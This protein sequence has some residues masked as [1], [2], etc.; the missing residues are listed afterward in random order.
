MPLVSIV[1]PTH[2]RASMVVRAVYSA[3]RQ[4]VR[5]VEIIVIDDA[6]SDDTEARLRKL[7]QEVSGLDDVLVYERLSR[8]SGANVARNRGLARAR[9]RYIAFLDSDDV[10]HPE[11]LA[12]QLGALRAGSEDHAFSYT[13]R[14]RVDEHYRVIARQLPTRTENLAQRIRHSNSI[15]TLSSVLVSTEVAQKSGGF[16]ESLAASQDWDFFIRVLPGC[17]ISVV[18]E[19]LVMY[20]DGAV[21]RISR[22]HRRRLKSHFVMYR[23]HLRGRVARR[24]LAEFYRNLAEDLEALG[25]RTLARR[26]YAQHYWLKRRYRKALIVALRL[27]ELSIRGDRYRSYARGLKRTRPSDDE[28]Y[29]PHFREILEHQM[30]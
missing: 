2:N 15:G 26:F 29:L 7:A 28:P 12:R 25:K 10:W 5:D 6:S 30:A 21:Q 22:N 16:D 13:G 24:E 18:R 4:T 8:N 20:F 19:P 3:F 14:Y 23:K 17:Q 11:K 9:G 1:I 27:R